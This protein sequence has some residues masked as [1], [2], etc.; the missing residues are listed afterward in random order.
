MCT[1][2]C[3]NVYKCPGTRENIKIIMGALEDV[4]NRLDIRGVKWRSKNEPC[5]PY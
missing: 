4:Y 1:K 5:E 2:L 3:S